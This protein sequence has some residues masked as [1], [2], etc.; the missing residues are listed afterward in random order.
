[1]LFYTTLLII[2]QQITLNSVVPM[3]LMMFIRVK[4]RGKKNYYYIVEGIRVAGK[5]Q[6]KVVR[7]VGTAEDL[8]KKLE[9]LD[10]L[11]SK[12]H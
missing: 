12:M 2:K 8:L 1:M 11:L 3:C 6:Q 7:Y 5:V 4:K 10:E 9:T